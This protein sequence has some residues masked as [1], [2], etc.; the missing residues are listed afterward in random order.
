MR[1]PRLLLLVPLFALAGA[2]VISGRWS[3]GAL[4]FT[5]D[6]TK[7]EECGENFAC[8]RQ[9]YGNLAYLEGTEAAG[10]RFRAALESEPYLSERCHLI[11]HSIGVAALAREQ[12]AAVKT[13]LGGFDDCTNGFYH[14]AM[15]TAFSSVGSD[16][17]SRLGSAGRE[18]CSDPLILADPQLTLNCVHGTGHGYLVATRGDLDRALAACAAA[19]EVG[20]RTRYWCDNGVFMEAFLPSSGEPSSEASAVDPFAPCRDRALPSP[21]E[22]YIYAAGLI[23][24][25][26][27]GDPE[28]ALDACVSAPAEGRAL[29]LENG[30]GL[31]VG[32]YPREYVAVVS[33]CREREGSLD[34]LR[35]AARAA[36]VGA[37][38]GSGD[39]ST[40]FRYCDAAPEGSGA[41]AFLLG[42][43][44]ASAPDGDPM[45]R[46]RAASD[47][48]LIAICRSGA[49]RREGTPTP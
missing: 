6:Q 2:A 37:L 22:C 24:E 13:L 34:C 36:A 8:L 30:G 31:A 4:E 9:A 33:L 49:E 41:C 7:I 46:C 40:A 43:I 35:G 17:P 12:G 47:E 38:S 11:A 44:L 32:A 3:S 5:P 45:E 26:A 18:I 16:D 20:Y 42:Q 23:S 19:G 29:C 39:L 21:S 1:W 48:T 25:L 15:L 28:K 14:G 27:D 10:A